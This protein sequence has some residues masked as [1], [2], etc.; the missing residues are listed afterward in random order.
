MS[1]WSVLIGRLDPK[2]DHLN[3]L[4]AAALTKR[5]HPRVRFVCVGDGPVTYRNTLRAQAEALGLVRELIW[6][7]ARV[8]VENVYNACDVVAL[9][10]AFGEGFPNVVGEAMACE[11]RCVV[12]NVGDAAVA[13]GEFGIVVP[14]RNSISLADGINCLLDLSEEDAR[15]M[16]SAARQR[17]ISLFSK[18]QLAEATSRVLWEILRSPRRTRF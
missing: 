1:R 12:T 15:A 13:I 9:S 4:K 3:F 18:R 2:K 5:R 8:L 7:P 6:S 14:P 10:S 16:G 11:K 17:I